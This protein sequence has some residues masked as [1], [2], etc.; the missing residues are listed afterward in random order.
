MRRHRNHIDA[1]PPGARAPV[2]SVLS[3]H[4][5]PSSAE[6]LQRGGTDGTEE[7]TPLVQQRTAVLLHQD[8]A[9]AATVAELLAN[10]GFL[11]VVCPS[12]AERALRS[13]REH[14]ADVFIAGIDIDG[15]RN[16]S[17]ERIGAALGRI[18][19]LKVIAVTNARDRDAIRQALRTGA[20]ACILDTA[21]PDDILLAVRQVFEPTIYFAHDLQH[22]IDND[23]AR[24]IDVHRAR[25]HP[26]ELEILALVAEGATNGEVA[27]RLW[28]SEQTVKF[29][30]NSIF[31]KLGV[32]SRTQASHWAHQHGLVGHSTSRT[33]G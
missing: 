7:A 31:K 5:W 14:R 10:D 25:L 33:D 18:R 29:H 27:R 21:Q 19:D 32:T 26:R 17:L 30:L 4:L 2:S 12:S 8:P 9:W 20:H 11:H 15:D 24:Q 28:I 22:E 6:D 3:L 16:A 23:L 13:L 1:A